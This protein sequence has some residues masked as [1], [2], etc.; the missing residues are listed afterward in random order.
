M[1]GQGRKCK[2]PYHRIVPGAARAQDLAAGVHYRPETCPHALRA[3]IFDQEKPQ[4]AL[5]RERVR[6]TGE[7]V[8]VVLPK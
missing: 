3:G 1:T 4:I 2:N 8:I 5:S 6:V 7:S